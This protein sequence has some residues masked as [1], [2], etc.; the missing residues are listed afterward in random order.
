MA[1]STR[2]WGTYDRRRRRPAA[3]PLRRG[4]G[5]IPRLPRAMGVT[6]PR[7]GLLTLGVHGHGGVAPLPPS[8]SSTRSHCPG[9]REPPVGTAVAS[10]PRWAPTTSGVRSG[11]SSCGAP[12]S[13][14]SSAWPRRVLTIAD[15][16]RR[17]DR[18]RLSSGARLDAGLMRV[19]EWFLVIPF[20]PLAIVLA[21]I[22]GRSVWNIIFVIGITSWPST[23]RLV[24]AQVLTV[25][26]RVF[27]DRARSL[28]ASDRHIVGHHI[29]PNVS[30]PDPGQ[31]HPGGPGVD[32]H[33]D[34]SRLPRAGR[35]AAASWGKTLEEAFV[36]GAITAAPGGTSSRP[37][38]GSCR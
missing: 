3:V 21:S 16:L 9:R 37:V 31:R 23:A 2:G 25:K 5:A 38:S 1:G 10:S 17:G 27:V 34:H 33:R 13:A 15:R 32:P 26:Q 29:L 12:G 11:P 7:I 24:R 35:S 28:G 36:N 6:R 20:L 4:P 18:R 8:E 22:L 30:G 19:T 14:C